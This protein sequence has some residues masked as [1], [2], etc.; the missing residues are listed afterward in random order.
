M[1]LQIFRLVSFPASSNPCKCTAVYSAISPTLASVKIN[2]EIMIFTHKKSTHIYSRPGISKKTKEPRLFSGNK[3]LKA[4]TKV[5]GN[6]FTV[7]C[8]REQIL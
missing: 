2:Q 7:N 4:L 5:K 8:I 6:H 1:C 3:K